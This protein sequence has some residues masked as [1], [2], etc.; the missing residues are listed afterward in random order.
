MYIDIAAVGCLNGVFR[1]VAVLNDKVKAA[2][3]CRISN[4]RLPHCDAVPESTVVDWP[5][6]GPRNALG[7]YGIKLYMSNGYS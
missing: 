7:F 6:D 4:G 2:A 1:F 5:P 3:L